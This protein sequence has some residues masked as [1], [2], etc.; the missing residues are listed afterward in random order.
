VKMIAENP[1]ELSKGILP[2]PSHQTII[3]AIES[4]PA[5]HHILGPFPRI[6]PCRTSFYQASTKSL[7]LIFKA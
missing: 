5:F 2:L 7:I 3:Y 4:S 1:K 6:L